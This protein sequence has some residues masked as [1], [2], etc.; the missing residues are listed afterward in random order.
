MYSH[1]KLVLVAL[2]D[3]IGFF[4]CCS[5]TLEKDVCLAIALLKLNGVSKRNH[6]EKF[7]VLLFVVVLLKLKIT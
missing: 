2:S 3:F 6:D 5:K 7:E 1:R 4:S